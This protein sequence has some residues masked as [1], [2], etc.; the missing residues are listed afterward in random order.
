M[1]EAEFRRFNVAAISAL[2]RKNA[3]LEERHGLGGYAR[4]DHDGDLGVLTFSNP[5]SLTGLVA[6]TTDIGSYSLKTKT[7]LWAW[8]NE[9][10]TAAERSKASRL[11]EL[12]R[13]TGMPI[14]RD[15]HFDCDEYLAWELA[16]ASVQHLGSIGCYR[17]PA[18]LLWIFLSINEI[19]VV[20]RAE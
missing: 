13:T 8:A 16:A 17:A 19:S 6:E 12:F 2:K 14:F 3:V 9:S 7:W 10:N 11:S 20:R 18:D 15:A 4:W 1:D 5:G